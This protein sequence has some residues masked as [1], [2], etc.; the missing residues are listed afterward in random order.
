MFARWVQSWIRSALKYFSISRASVDWGIQMPNHLNPLLKLQQE[1]II[2]FLSCLQQ[3]LQQVALL[4]QP[5]IP[6]INLCYLAIFFG[7]NALL[8]T[9]VCWELFKCSPHYQQSVVKRL[10]E[11]VAEKREFEQQM[12][13]VQRVGQH[14]NVI[15]LRAY[16][17]SKDEKLLI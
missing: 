7:K 1:L 5:K 6:D 17:Y 10:K 14:L 12:E 4:C 11:V 2:V 13:N 8:N 15:P 16:Y 9:Q 3:P